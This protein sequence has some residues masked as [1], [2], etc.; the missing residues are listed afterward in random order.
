M[1]KRD[2]VSTVSFQ[3]PVDIDKGLDEASK[4]FSVSKADILRSI[5][6]DFLVASGIMRDMGDFDS[7]DDVV[8]G[9]E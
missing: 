8:I 7:P 3:L 1:V 4:K 6:F 2:F 5:S 9:Q